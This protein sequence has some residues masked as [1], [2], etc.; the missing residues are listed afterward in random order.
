MPTN[1]FYLPIYR[2][3]DEV[4]YKGNMYI[5]DMVYIAG[6]KI[7]LKLRDIPELIESSKVEI[8]RFIRFEIKRKYD[9]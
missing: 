3:G 4:L 5:I 1:E 9:N 8:N 2:A 7:F 6:K